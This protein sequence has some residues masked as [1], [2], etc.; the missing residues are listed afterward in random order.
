MMDSANQTGFQGWEP[1]SPLFRQ[2]KVLQATS[3]G[4]TPSRMIMI[5][6]NDSQ[7]R[8]GNT[9]YGIVGGHNLSTT[10]KSKFKTRQASIGGAAYKDNSLTI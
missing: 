8:V 4:M 7:S 3:G 9:Q 5:G 6:D 1:S 2:A 10:S